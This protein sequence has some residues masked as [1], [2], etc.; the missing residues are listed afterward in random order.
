MVKHNKKFSL[1][2]EE[3]S[4]EAS[5]LKKV[6]DS[7]SLLQLGTKQYTRLTSQNGGGKF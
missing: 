6:V 5:S 4:G 2:S 1:L 3:L 7:V